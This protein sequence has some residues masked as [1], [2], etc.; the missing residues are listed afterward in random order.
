MLQYS[1]M[2]TP[3]LQTPRDAARRRAPRESRGNPKGA[4]QGPSLVEGE[5]VQEKGAFE[6]PPSPAG[7]FAFFWR[8]CQKKVA[9]AGAK[10]PSDA[11]YGG[12]P[13]PQGCP[14]SL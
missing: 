10:H 6:L 5:E 9:P 14:P 4:P 1:Q 3:E 2:N 8:C 7:A 13:P 12:E 11:A